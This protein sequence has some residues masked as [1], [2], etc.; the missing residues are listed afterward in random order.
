[1]SP[2]LGLGNNSGLK[3]LANFS[4]K[5]Y[6]A[7][8]QSTFSKSSVNTAHFHQGQPQTSPMLTGDIKRPVPTRKLISPDT[9]PF[10]KKGE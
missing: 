5:L 7:P 9:L 8:Q 2:K 3:A 6:P 10:E 1:M 4:M